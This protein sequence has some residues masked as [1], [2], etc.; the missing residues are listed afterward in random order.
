M[1][2]NQSIIKLPVIVAHFLALTI[3]FKNFKYMQKN[4]W[5]KALNKHLL[6]E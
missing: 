2:E 4:A 3:L 5:Y 1:I 6:N